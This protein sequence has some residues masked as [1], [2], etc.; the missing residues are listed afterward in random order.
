[1]EISGRS[2]SGQG[3]ERELRKCTL[4]HVWTPNGRKEGGNLAR[5]GQ[6][7][8]KRDWFCRVFT[9]MLFWPSFLDSAWEIFC[10][11]WK[12]V[13]GQKKGV[14]RGCV[15]ALTLALIY[16]SDASFK[17]DHRACLFVDF[18]L[19]KKKILIKLPY[20]YMQVARIWFRSVG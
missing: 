2:R 16:K 18:N 17:T 4:T 11:R 20:N 5:Q 8:G 3:I 15:I 19:K 6:M 13:W 14:N 1:M 7:L 10:N 9:K 12:V